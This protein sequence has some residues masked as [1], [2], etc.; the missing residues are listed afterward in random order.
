MMRFEGRLE[1]RWL[2]EVATWYVSTTPET[3]LT[4]NNESHRDLAYVV[5][6]VTDFKNLKIYL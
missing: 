4:S 3:S 1:V 6:F 2:I 5:V